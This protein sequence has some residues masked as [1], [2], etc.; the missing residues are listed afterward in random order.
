M[1]NFVLSEKEELFDVLYYYRNYDTIIAFHRPWP[2]FVIYSENHPEMKLALVFHY[3]LKRSGKY[4]YENKF[5]SK[6]EGLLINIENGVVLKNKL[7][8]TIKSIIEYLNNED[9][10][11]YGI[12]TD[13]YSH[14]TIQEYIDLHKKVLSI[15]EKTGKMEPVISSIADFSKKIKKLEDVFHYKID[16][17]TYKGTIHKEDKMKIVLLESAPNYKFYL[18]K[19]EYGGYYLKEYTSGGNVFSLPKGGNILEI[20]ETTMN[21]LSYPIA[22]LLSD[23]SELEGAIKN[24]K[25]AQRKK[26]EKI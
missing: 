1:D 17:K 8:G 15:A 9:I 26:F 13:E 23:E 14:Y 24:F 2:G 6:K 11:S 20:L 3:P 5:T 7:D 4:T 19:N 18:E 21:S 12:D 16:D 10:L 25:E 22:L